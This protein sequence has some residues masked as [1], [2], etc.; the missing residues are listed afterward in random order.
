MYVL[1][2]CLA[3]GT[4]MYIRKLS[5][6]YRKL[7]PDDVIKAELQAQLHELSLCAA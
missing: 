7:L 5:T 2:Q 4:H 1:L 3:P 6:S